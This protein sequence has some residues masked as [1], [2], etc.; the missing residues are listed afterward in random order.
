MKQMTLFQGLI[1]VDMKNLILCC[2]LVKE[3][4]FFWVV[5]LVNSGIS[6]KIRSF[7]T[8]LK[9]FRLV[10]MGALVCI[11]RYSWNSFRNG[12]CCS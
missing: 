3:D 5:I 2:I 11:C 8:V 1:L 9:I 4:V 7:P 10:F 12:V 6:C